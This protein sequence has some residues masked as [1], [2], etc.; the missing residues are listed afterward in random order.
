MDLYRFGATE[1]DAIDKLE[2]IA[3]YYDGVLST[4]P[5][6]AGLDV[7]A[8]S[9]A[10]FVSMTTGNY[11]MGVSGVGSNGLAFRA[12]MVDFGDLLP[13]SFE[14][15][16]T[17]GEKIKAAVQKVGDKI[18]EAFQKLTNWIFKDAIQKAA[19]LFLYAFIKDAPTAKIA[20]KKDRQLKIVDFIANATGSTRETVLTAVAAEITRLKGLTPAQILNK[21]AGRTI[22]GG[23]ILE[24]AATSV[25]ALVGVPPSVSSTIIDIIKK[26]IALFKKKDSDAPDLSDAEPSANDF[27]EVTPNTGGDIS[28]P[29]TSIPTPNGAQV[30]IPTPA[31]GGETQEVL[32]ADKLPRTAAPSTG[33][34]TV[35]L[36]GAA[37][38]VALVAFNK[39]RGKKKKK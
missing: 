30:N 17:L 36:L 14:G 22:A 27:D 9:Q 21:V 3:N 31:S 16:G 1:S 32:D 8:L 18:K 7:T 5:A 35:L 34:N 13:P 38:A 33:S 11:S 4:I 19:P 28:T 2:A 15:V 26:I 23:A 39:G 12:P 24:T 25:A 6:T 29:T 37:A 20:K 10:Q